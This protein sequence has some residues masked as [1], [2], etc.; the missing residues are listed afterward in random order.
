MILRKSFNAND[1]IFQ[2]V[3]DGLR[4]TD[5]KLHGRD[6]YLVSELIR[7]LVQIRFGELTSEEAKGKTGQLQKRL[8]DTAKFGTTENLLQ[9]MAGTLR[10]GSVKTIHISPTLTEA[11]L[12]IE[13]TIQK[14]HYSTLAG[15]FPELKNTMDAE[16]AKITLQELLSDSAAWPRRAGASIFSSLLT[17]GWQHGRSALLNGQG[18]RTLTAR[19]CAR[20]QVCLFESRLHHRRRYPG[21]HWRQNLGDC[22]WC[23]DL[24][25]N[26]QSHLDE[27]SHL[28]PEDRT[29][30]QRSAIHE[31]LAAGHSSFRTAAVKPI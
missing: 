17:A 2:T 19:S 18:N 20:Q 15:V 11:L 31:G 12:E 5:K 23:S 30:L 14:I 21:T 28:G 29:S 25:V 24:H 27:S 1:L 7:Q 10:A 26:H 6:G 8:L 22:L 13:G 4:E 3:E 16:F 9:F